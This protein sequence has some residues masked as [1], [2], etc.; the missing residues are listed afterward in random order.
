MAR[1]VLRPPFALDHL[2]LLGDDLIAIKLEPPWREQPRAQR[3]RALQAI[4]PPERD[5]EGV[6]HHVLGLGS[7]PQQPIDHL[8][9]AGRVANEDRVAGVAVPSQCARDELRV[10]HRLGRL[11]RNRS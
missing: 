9:H 11:G 7:I 3:R 4:E 5:L 6:R 1:Y 10:A 8:R 2:E